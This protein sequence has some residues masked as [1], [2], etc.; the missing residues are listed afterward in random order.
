MSETITVEL[1]AL[2]FFANHGLHAEEALAGNEFEVNLTAMFPARQHITTLYD[3]IDY[4]EIYE[5][6]KQNF[7]E[8]EALLETVA[9]KIAGAIEAEFKTIL[10]LQLT[11][12]KLNPPIASFTGTVGITYTKDFR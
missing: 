7:K 4:T 10:R 8:T 9:Q 11:I 2:R 1:K 6:V 3:T 12:T 5:L